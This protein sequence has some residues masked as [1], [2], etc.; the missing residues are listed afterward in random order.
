MSSI[1]RSTVEA[2][3]A[4][5]PDTVL[6]IQVRAADLAAAYRQG[7][8]GPAFF[9]PQQAAALV[10]WT[11]AQWAAWC[12]QGR[13]EGAVKEGKGWRLPKEGVQRFVDRKL[14]RGGEE[15]EL[16]TRR[17]KRKPWKR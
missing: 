9:T 13:V 10:G 15:D 1:D 5:A 12:R 11:P 16:S 6:T 3:A 8:P 2:I 7:L 17:W 14:R 4:L